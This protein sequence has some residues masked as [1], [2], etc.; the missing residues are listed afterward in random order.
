M[1]RENRITINVLVSA[2]LL[3][4]FGTANAA[5]QKGTYLIFDGVNTAMTVLWQLDSSQS[6]T[7]NWGED[8]LYSMGTADTV[9]NGSGI[10]DHQHIYTITGLNP[11]TKYFY[12][13]S[14]NL[15]NGG[16]GTF[17]TAPL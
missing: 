9:E 3:V 12:Q 16:N 10:Y 15:D 1:L 6:C 14:C 5:V 8:I 13:V 11:G 7:I 2:L 17:Y 4:F